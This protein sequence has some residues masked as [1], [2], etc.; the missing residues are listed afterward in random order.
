MSTVIK[1]ILRKVGVGFSARL[2]RPRL[3]LVLAIALAS[4]FVSPAIAQEVRVLTEGAFSSGFG[5]DG[6]L[7]GVRLVGEAPTGPLT[8]R[9]EFE[10][11]RA[12]KIGPSAAGSGQA[13]IG[14]IEIPIRSWRL[15]AGAKWSRF[16]NDLWTKEGLAPR[17]GVARESLRHRFELTYSGPDD[18][19][20]H[21]ETLE[22]SGRTYVGRLV[23]EAA[24]LHGRFDQGIERRDGSSVRLGL[25]WLLRSQR[26]GAGRQLGSS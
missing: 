5:F 3:K 8:L 21:L 2:W 4:F 20:N 14:E 19:E 9:G 18:T 15:F 16:S 13:L 26:T 24:Y 7:T 6:P 25:G 17:L 11:F 1:W 22:V 23:L 10:T 12:D